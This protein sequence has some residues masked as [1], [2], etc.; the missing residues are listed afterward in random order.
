MAPTC[1][2]R[3]RCNVRHVDQAIYVT[4]RQAHAMN[5]EARKAQRWES[6]GNLGAVKADA[7]GKDGA[8]LRVVNVGRRKV[9]DEPHRLSSAPA[10]VRANAAT[11]ASP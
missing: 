3:C 10:S 9:G 1:G 6:L 8:R 7:A 5:P 4:C 11:R 2:Q